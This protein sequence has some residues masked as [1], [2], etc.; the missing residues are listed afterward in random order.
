[1]TSSHADD[2][3]PFN[4]RDNI[5]RGGRQTSNSVHL[6]FLSAKSSKIEGVGLGLSLLPVKNRGAVQETRPLHERGQPEY[7]T[8]KTATCSS[9]LFDQ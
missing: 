7:Q 5:A 8:Q 2:E 3:S 9:E 1:V 6:S 4:I